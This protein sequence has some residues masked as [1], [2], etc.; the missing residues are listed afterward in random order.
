MNMRI[1]HI[2]NSW[3]MHTLLSILPN[4]DTQYVNMP[5]PFTRTAY[6]LAY[7]TYVGRYIDISYQI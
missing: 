6:C 5:K 7:L 3:A 2:L 4:M 1:M